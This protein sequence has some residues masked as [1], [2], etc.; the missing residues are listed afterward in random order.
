MST[1]SRWSLLAVIGLGVACPREAE[2]PPDSGPRDTSPPDTDPP[3]TGSDAPF[4][5]TFTL[6]PSEVVPTVVTATWTTA[7]PV[8]CTLTYSVEGEPPLTTVEGGA[9]STAHEVALVGLPPTAEASLVVSAEASG[10]LEQSDRQHFQTGALPAGVSSLT[11][12]VDDP[13]R[14][15]HG[16][17][18]VPLIDDASGAT[19]VCVFDDAGRAVW[20]Y[21]ARHGCGRARLAPDGGGLLFHDEDYDPETKKGVGAV[22]SVAWDGTARWRFEHVGAHHDFAILGEDRFVTLGTTTTTLDPG[23]PGE[24]V[25]KGD[26]L[27]EFDSAGNERQI[28]SVFDDL[29][30][31]VVSAS[32][33]VQDP[34]TGT[35]DWSHGNYL[36]WVPK[37]GEVLVSLRNIDAIVAVDVE[38][39]R[40][41]WSLSNTW[42]TYQAEGEEPLLAWPH[43]AELV[44]GG[45]LI[46]NQTWASA[47]DACSHAAILALDADAG[48]ATTTWQY[49]PPECFKVFFLGSAQPLPNGD[50]LSVFSQG[51]V[52]DEVSPDGA[53]VARA[54]SP[55]G[56]I[57]G[58]AYRTAEL[59]PVAQ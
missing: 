7:E 2:P 54:I 48:V 49:K 42:G 16:F 27:I 10:G 43:S 26:T 39:G 33:C 1:L 53:G 21:P 34:A 20:A 23:G 13:E 44:E 41:T 5:G 6:T 50:L 29:D 22:T 31:A 45:L 55:T 11:V 15:F 14:V 58:Y 3:D 36:T 19:W 47:E 18:V 35:W 24:Q 46:F 37:T 28:W 57:V 40:M 59:R 8:S 52:M 4:F 51:G 25:L 32:D 38:A 56:W 9:P 17:T 30:P 12:E